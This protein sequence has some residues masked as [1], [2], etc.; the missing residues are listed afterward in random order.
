LLIILSLLIY[1][2]LIMKSLKAVSLAIIRLEC[3]AV[4]V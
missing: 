3:N 2:C 1:K 4:K